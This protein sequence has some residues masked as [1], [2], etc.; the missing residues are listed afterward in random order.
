VIEA[1]AR[2]AA[3]WIR[4][5]RPPPFDE[6]VSCALRRD[7]DVERR[8]WL[9]PQ[10]GMEA[11]AHL[12]PRMRN[13]A[14]AGPRWRRCWGLRLGGGRDRVCSA[15]FPW[16]NFCGTM[17][18]FAAARIFPRAGLLPTPTDRLLPCL[19]MPTHGVSKDFGRQLICHGVYADR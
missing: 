5:G 19:P 3:D 17:Q 8:Q 1:A 2:E 9:G 12:V 11:R 10:L 15:G 7:A 16:A 4:A 14:A 6:D 13:G 18:I